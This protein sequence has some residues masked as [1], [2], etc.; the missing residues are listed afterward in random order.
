M[1]CFLGSRDSSILSIHR[2]IAFFSGLSAKQKQG[3]R[4]IWIYRILLAN[5]TSSKHVILP[6][7]FSYYFHNLRYSPPY[8]LPTH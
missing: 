6:C 1:I 5:A 3:A 8:M 2:F 7:V 4:D